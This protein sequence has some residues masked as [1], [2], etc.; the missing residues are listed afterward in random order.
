MGGAFIECPW[1]N[2]RVDFA[3]SSSWNSP[4]K[5][6]Y[7]TILVSTATVDNLLSNVEFL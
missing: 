1:L 2:F 7:L 4:K 5:I 3:V 6:I